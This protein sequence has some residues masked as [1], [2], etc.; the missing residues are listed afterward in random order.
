MRSYPAYSYGWSYPQ[1]YCYTT[2]TAS[3]AYVPASVDITVEDAD[4][5]RTFVE[6]ITHPWGAYPTTSDL[7]TI[8]RLT[9]NA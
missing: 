5:A 9:A 6:T 3:T 7:A 4:Y 1:P 8:D 2:T